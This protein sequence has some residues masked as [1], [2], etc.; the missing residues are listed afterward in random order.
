MVPMSAKSKKDQR[1]KICMWSV[2]ILQWLCHP[3]WVDQIDWMG[4]VCLWSRVWDSRASSEGDLQIFRKLD[5]DTTVA[6][7]SY[8]LSSIVPRRVA[9][10]KLFF[11]VR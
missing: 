1:W 2:P 8:Q 5:S 3:T 9:L 11:W 7:V 4:A 10:V 6:C